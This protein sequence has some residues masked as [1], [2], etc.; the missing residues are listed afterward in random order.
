MKPSIPIAILGPTASGKTKLA[1]ALGLKLNGEIISIDSRQVYQGMDIGTGKDLDEYQEVPYHLINILPAGARYNVFQFQADTD[2]A[3]EKISA[4]GKQAILCGGTGMYFQAFL[5][6]YAYTQIPKID[7]LRAVLEEKTTEELYGIFN[8]GQ[9]TLFHKVANTES[10]KRLIRA[11]EISEFLRENPTFTVEDLPPRQ[12]IIFGLDL[13]AEVRRSRIDQRLQ[14]RLEQGLVKEVQTLLEQGLSHEMLQYYG[15]EY[16][17]T[18][19]LLLGELSF[20]TFCDKL[21]TAIHQFAK[22]QMTYF[23]KLERD[24]H[25]IHWLN[26]EL[27][28]EKQVD[29]VLNML[30]KQ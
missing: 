12:V 9:E 10:R 26:A 20:D 7:S 19:Q 16:K 18:S 21:Q 3:L 17:Y 1:V 8:K 14:L 28:I 15:L 27:P 23:R 4:K 2:F 29:F 24:G 22:R 5:D 30:K 25:H 11:I 6:N 13:E